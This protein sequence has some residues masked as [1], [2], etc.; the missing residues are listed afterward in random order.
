MQLAEGGLPVSHVLAASLAGETAFGTFAPSQPIFWPQGRPL[1][2]GEVIYQ[3]D[4]ARTFRGLAEHGRD[5][6]YQRSGGPRDRR[7]LPGSTAAPSATRTWPPTAPAGRSPSAPA[8]AATPSTRAPPNSSGHVLLQELNLVEGFD[9]AAL[10]WHSA[11]DVH[12]MVEAKKLA[13]ADRERYL[14]DPDF[15]D[16]PIEGLISKAYAAERRRLIDPAA[17]GP[18]RTASLPGNPGAFRPASDCPKTPPASSSSTA[19]A[20]PSASCRAC[21]PA[22]APRW[23]PP[24]PA[25]C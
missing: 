25:S 9:L 22:S 16:V 7:R 24:A 13:F 23:S 4:L 12:L 18:H 10:G 11:G 19:T 8:T 20:T 3:R 1:R 14:A 21:R 5:Y 17:R 6:F 15:V 2:A